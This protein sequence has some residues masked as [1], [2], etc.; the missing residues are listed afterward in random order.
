MIDVTRIHLVTHQLPIVDDRY[1]AHCC[2]PL[3]IDITPIR[4]R[5]YAAHECL[6]CT[7]GWDD[8]ERCDVDHTPHCIYIACIDHTNNGNHITPPCGLVDAHLRSDICGNSR[9]PNTEAVHTLAGAWRGGSWVFTVVGVCST[10][11]QHSYGY[12]GKRNETAS[13]KSKTKV[14]INWRGRG[15]LRASRPGRASRVSAR[16]WRDS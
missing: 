1:N 3:L 16:T 11:S 10:V 4:T 8:H 15:A 6:Y 13:S 9:D 7:D 12:F 14:P 2:Y 5:G